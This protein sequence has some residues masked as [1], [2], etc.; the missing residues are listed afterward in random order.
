MWAEL[1][2]LEGRMTK[3]INNLLK[4]FNKY[5]IKRAIEL[6][7]KESLQPSEALVYD[8]ETII[9]PDYR[10]VKTP[11]QVKEFV[12]D[13]KRMPLQSVELRRENPNF[14]LDSVAYSKRQEKQANSIPFKSYWPSFQSLDETQMKW[15]FYW[16]KEVLSGNY[17]DTNPGYIFIFV[18][19]LLNYTFND[20]AAFNLSMLDRVYMNFYDKHSA[21]AHFLP[22]WIGDF[23]YE[24]GDSELEKKWV[25]KL[26]THENSD[27]ENLK[28]CEHKLQTVSITFWKRFIN[29]RKTKIF[30]E[31]R[32]VIYKVFKASVSIL[33]TQYQAQGKNLIDEWIP[34]IDKTGYER[35]MFRNAIIGREVQ[36]KLEVNR[37]PTLKMRE[38][39]TALFRLAENVARLIAG[40]KRQLS[41]DEARLP[42]GF[43][44]VL[45]QLFLDKSEPALIAQ[46]R[47]VKTKDSGDRVLGSPV[48]N[49][50]EPT[51]PH[52]ATSPLIEFNLERINTLDKESKELLE[53]FA[54]WYDE[55]ESDLSEERN[56]LE[57][58]KNF[59]HDQ[60]Q[61]QTLNLPS[62]LSLDEDVECFLAML[63]ELEAEFLRGFKHLTRA[64]QEVMQ[65]LKSHGI[66]MG[67]FISTVNG[68]ALEYLGDNLIE[69]EADILRLNE[70]FEQVLFSLARKA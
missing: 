38:D 40:E 54:L 69:Q 6:V 23:C 41:V 65:T 43:K 61:K 57:I 58:P 22:Q 14:C 30:R 5:H 32:N 16:R 29:Y 1:Q 18:Y 63:N 70:D 55:E 4:V 39:L 11:F 28:R 24:L 15:Y 26:Q 60:L 53:I 50:P 7:H 59:K 44:N 56:D 33:E 67:V 47:F 19:E 49:S 64:T 25:D 48:P 46:G 27:Y 9:L 68:K 31:N 45:V 12:R 21:L 52:I 51:E 62:P 42:E 3:M 37:R 17:I 36:R 13:L 2:E 8:I 35:E 66:M 10:H 34:Q 20:Q